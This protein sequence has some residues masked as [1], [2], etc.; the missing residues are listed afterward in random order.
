MLTNRKL[1]VLLIPP[2]YWSGIGAMARHLAK[3]FKNVDYYFF[4]C[5]D[6]RNHFEEFKRLLD[7][8]DIVHWLANLSWLDLPS[9]LNPLNFSV[10]SIATVHHV[11]FAADDNGKETRKIS[12]ASQCNV[13]HVVS[14]EW[15]DVVKMQTDKPVFLAHHVINPQQFTHNRYSYRPREPFQ[16]GTFGFAKT[17]NDRKRTDVLLNALSILKRKN[18]EFELVVQGPHWSSFEEIFRQNGIKVKN[19][20]YKSHNHA[21]NSYRAIDIYVCSSDVE[22]GPLPVLE[23]LASGVPVVS[24][25]VGVAIEALSLGGGLLVEKGNPPEL[26]TAISTLMDDLQLYRKFCGEAVKISEN[27]SWANVENEYLHMYEYTLAKRKTSSRN[28]YHYS[29]L[30]QRTIQLSRS[31]VIDSMILMKLRHIKRLIL[32]LAK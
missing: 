26:A 29:P 28:S 3:S 16:I 1:K 18:Y 24:T 2:D 11:D 7:H 14:Q 32:K 13:I 31:A 12:A 27:F 30:I 15:L 23:A 22:G 25:R 20:G 4:T 17:M 10:P 9:D 19:L 5:W 8:V 6:I 21:L